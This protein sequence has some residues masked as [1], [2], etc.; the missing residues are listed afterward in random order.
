MNTPSIDN[1]TRQ[2][3]APQS[4]TVYRQDIYV[5]PGKTPEE[6][7]SVIVR[8]TGTLAPVTGGLGLAIGGVTEFFGQ[9]LI[10]QPNPPFP[11]QRTALMFPI[12]VKSLYDACAKLM[13][14]AWV[15]SA[16][17]AAIADFNRQQAI[18]SVRGGR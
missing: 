8:T 17:R 9:F 10:E 6:S 7:R 14:D 1:E 11:P 2:P 13:D 4:F 3:V 12:P 16:C 18:A 5:I 15:Q